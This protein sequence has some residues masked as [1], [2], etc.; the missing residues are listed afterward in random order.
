MVIN[1][2]KVSKTLISDPSKFSILSRPS[3]FA[4]NKSNS[5]YAMTDNTS[6]RILLNSSKQHQAPEAANPLKNFPTI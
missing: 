1:T 2:Q 6:K 4:P 3:A 5:Y